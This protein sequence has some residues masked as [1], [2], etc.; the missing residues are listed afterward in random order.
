M[1]TTNLTLYID[2]LKRL[3]ISI[4]I[5]MSS[6]VLKHDVDFF[7]SKLI[8]IDAK[9]NE[10]VRPLMKDMHEKTMAL[11]NSNDFGSHSFLPILTEFISDL[12]NNER[13]YQK[14]RGWDKLPMAPK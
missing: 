3:K 6:T 14:S 10:R 2:D 9:R 7:A 1:I 5:G 8:G 4:E 12:E 11:M 13:E